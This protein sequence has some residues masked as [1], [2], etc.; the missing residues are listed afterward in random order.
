[1]TSGE[2]AV[3]SLRG[4]GVSLSGTESALREMSF[5]VR[6]TEGSPR[7]LFV[8]L[9]EWSFRLGEWGALY[10]DPHTLDTLIVDIGA[11]ASGRVLINRNSEFRF[12]QFY[13]QWVVKLLL[14]GTASAFH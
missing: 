2:G 3:V 12:L 13:T 4:S 10:A 6:G 11:G 8:L 14:L 1:V 9:W 5:L 7:E